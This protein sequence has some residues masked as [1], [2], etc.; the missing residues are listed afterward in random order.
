ML[1]FST[2]KVS[3]GNADA[4][5]SE[6]SEIV[7]VAVN[8]TSAR[9][10]TYTAIMSQNTSLMHFPAGVDMSDSDLVNATTIE[11]LFSYAQSVLV[12]VFND[13]EPALA[14]TI[15]DQ[16]TT[17]MTA[18]FQITF[19]WFSTGQDNGYVNVTYTGLG[20]ANLTQYNEW[21]M[22]QCL[23]TDLE[24]FSLTFL[25]MTQETG[26]STLVSASKDIGGFDWMYTMMTT[27]ET[28]TQ[29]GSDSHMIDILDLLNV[30]S[31]APSLYAEYFGGVCMS[32]VMLT[33]VSNDTISYTSCEP[34]LGEPPAS[35]WVY[36]QMFPTSLTAYYY[37]GYDPVPVSPLSFTFDGTIIPEFATLTLT[38]L[39]ISAIAFVLVIRKRFIKSLS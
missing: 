6:L 30:D 8:C 1:A 5:E 33:I 21:L 22:S 29:V 9:V 24:G 23:A 36:F 35:G 37:F 18:S 4:V 13:T 17:S 28:S 20:K 32:L 2:N 12:Y 19:S 38:A 7:G 25:P 16:I 3:I 10:N 27:Y 31:L 14:R 11:L 15:S 26:A 34:G 39:F